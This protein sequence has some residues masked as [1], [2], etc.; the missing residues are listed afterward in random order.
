M[1]TTLNCPLCGHRFKS[2]EAASCQ[3]CPLLSDC[4]MVCCPQC[5]Y[6]MVDVKRSTWGRLISKLLTKGAKVE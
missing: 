6:Q 2:D 5:G 3:T 4:A 1:E